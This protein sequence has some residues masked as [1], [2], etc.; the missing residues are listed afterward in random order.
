MWTAIVPS[1]A[2]HSQALSLL[3]TCVQ[4]RTFWI[5]GNQQI[6]INVTFEDENSSDAITSGIHT[7]IQYDSLID[8]TV[9]FIHKII[10]RLQIQ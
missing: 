5:L 10:N 1:N 9:T 4:F 6:D 3:H 7:L 8:N 2:A